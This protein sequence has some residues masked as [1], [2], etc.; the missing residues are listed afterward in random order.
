[1]HI[2]SNKCGY[3]KI[4]TSS[5]TSCDIFSNFREED[6]FAIIKGGPLAPSICGKALLYQLK[7]GVYI[8]VYITGI[9]ANDVDLNRGKMFS[10]TFHAFH[11]HELG[12]CTVGN[13][14]DPFLAAGGHWNIEGNPHEFHTGDLPPLLANNGKVMMSFLTQRFML[15]NALNRSFILHKNYDTIKA[16]PSGNAGSRLAC[17]LIKSKSH[18]CCC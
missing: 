7:D 18:N 13:P 4:N 12:N 5:C 1:M 11:I 8:R 3:N 2:N 6:A 15:K 9:P 16:Q 14:K 17:G 10:N